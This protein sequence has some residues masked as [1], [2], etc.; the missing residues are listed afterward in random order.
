MAA[1]SGSGAPEEPRLVAV[2]IDPKG[3]IVLPPVVRQALR[4]KPNQSLFLLL[5]EGH[6][7]LGTDPERLR[8]LV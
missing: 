4:V 8:G 6:V 1:G 2:R 5:R 7:V 3:R